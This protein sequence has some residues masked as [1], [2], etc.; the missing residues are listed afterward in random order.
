MVIGGYDTTKNQLTMTMKLLVERPT[1]YT[2]CA[3]NVEFCGK[4]VNEAL[5]HSAT[6]SPFRAVDDDFIYGDIN[7]RKGETLV[8]ATPLVGRDRV[9]F[10]QPETFDPE[11]PN[12]NRL[13]V[14]SRQPCLPGPLYG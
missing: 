11:R 14:W 10:R 9:V 12:A 3:Q 13:W 4:V 1:L 5:R 6:V 2:R 8:L 7:L